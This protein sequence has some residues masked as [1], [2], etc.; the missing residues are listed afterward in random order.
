MT[1]AKNA[2]LWSDTTE[3]IWTP[4]IVS[5]LTDGNNDFHQH[6]LKFLPETNFETSAS[7]FP[8]S[9]DGNISETTT[10]NNNGNVLECECTY[11]NIS[12]HHRYHYH[13][14]SVGIESLD[15][16]MELLHNRN[17]RELKM[18]N[19]MDVLKKNDKF[20]STERVIFA[21]G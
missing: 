19:T 21:V 14:S 9:N 6:H 2:I 8:I 3:G 20:N 18:Q 4:L 5:Q 13:H 15:S 17:D 7:K 10:A 11:D 1:T 12:Y 16:C